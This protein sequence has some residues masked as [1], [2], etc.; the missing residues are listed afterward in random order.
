MLVA[1]TGATGFVGQALAQRLREEGHAVRGLVRGSSAPAAVER[2]RRL[3]VL[4]VE[5]DVGEPD[6]LRALL[7]R[8]ELAV[9]GAALIAYRPRLH[10]AMRRINVD[11]TANV[12]AA[13]RSAGVGRLVHVSSIAAVGIRADRELM[14][15]DSPWEAGSLRM[16]YLDTKRAAEQRV[17]E[18]V[19]RGLDAVVV[20]PAAIYGPSS[21][22]SNSSGLVARIAAGR[23]RVAPEGGINVVPLET[24]VAGI[25]AAAERGR[26]G[27]RYI[28]GGENLELA[29][30]VARIARAA[31][32]RLRPLVL[33]G[34]TGAPL[35]AAMNAVDRLVPLSAWYTPDLCGAF[36]RW[37]WFDTTRMNVELGVRAS[38]VDACL[39]ATVAQLRRDGRLPAA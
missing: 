36:G 10:A 3:G 8:A 19:G 28:L 5:G 30:L 9:H 13:C 4:L 24:V 1:L 15:E 18:E 16:A 27:R 31:G 11:G 33:P 37:M 14:D 6:S 17:A 38:D 21:A 7:A 12:A 2:L 29:G 39:A 20:N 22:A 26:R 32:R 35:R 25:L 23:L 34:W